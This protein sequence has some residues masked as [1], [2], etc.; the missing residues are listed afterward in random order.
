MQ[1]VGGRA[2]GRWLSRY[3]NDSQNAPKELKATAPNVLPLANSHMPASNWAIP[4]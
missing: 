2:F 4:P 3:Q 1:H